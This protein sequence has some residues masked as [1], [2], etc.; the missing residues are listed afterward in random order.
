MDLVPIMARLTLNDKIYINHLRGG[1]QLILPLTFYLFRHKR[2]LRAALYPRLER[3]IIENKLQNR[4]CIIIFNRDAEFKHF[5][6]IQRIRGIPLRITSDLITRVT[7]ATT[8]YVDVPLTT[9]IHM[10]ITRKMLRAIWRGYTFS[11]SLYHLNTY[12]R[13]THTEDYPLILSFSSLYGL[14]EV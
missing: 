1:Y 13:P 12:L 2:D 7:N 14:Y 6:E 3:L 4:D 9:L 5:N 11:V 10:R 8:G